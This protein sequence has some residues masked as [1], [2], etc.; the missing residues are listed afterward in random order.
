MSFY[1]TMVIV[2]QCAKY[3]VGILTGSSLIVSKPSLDVKYVKSFIRPTA[4]TRQKDNRIADG[5]SKLNSAE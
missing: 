5:G 4:P 3:L 1:L 2:V